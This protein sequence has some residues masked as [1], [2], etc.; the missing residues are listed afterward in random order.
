VAFAA[1]AE[2]HTTQSGSLKVTNEDDTLVTVET[3][4][5]IGGDY[6]TTQ[7]FRYEKPRQGDSINRLIGYSG[8][9]VKNSLILQKVVTTEFVPLYGAFQR[10]KLDC[11]VLLPG[12]DSSQ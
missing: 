8:G 10:L 11:D 6:V 12:V 2:R 1:S 3:G 5:D 4:S 7:R 9:Y